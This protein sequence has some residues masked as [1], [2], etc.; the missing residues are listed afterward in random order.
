MTT[1]T[2]T[3][4]L[5]ARGLEVGY[6]SM[7]YVR[8]LDLEI[9]PGEIV[10]LLGANGAGKTTTI[11]GLAGALRPSAGHVELG[12]S[13]TTAP[14]HRRTRDGMAM[15]TQERCVFM[16]LSVREN[17]RVGRVDPDAALHYFPE[18]AD[19]L[20][21]PVGLLSGG[22]QQM[23]A[24]ARAIARGPRVLL[25]DE[26]SLGLAPMIVD[27]ILEV[28]TTAC[29]ESGLG[30]LLVEQQVAK[31]LSVADRGV[32]LRRGRLE[33]SDTAAALRTRRTE[34]EALYL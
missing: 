30:V 26:L 8:D 14:T 3:P 21:R 11:L 24:V 2:T 7:P 32:V 19:H 31:A 10:A 33:L 23:L 18:L 16:A 1:A 5:A 9:Y 6:G 25:A 20:S 28:L 34:V 13:R 17:L 15:V 12:G 27:R 22:Q 29:R 4:V